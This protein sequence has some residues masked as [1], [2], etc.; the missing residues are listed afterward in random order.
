MRPEGSWVVTGFDA[1]GEGLR[2]PRRDSTLT[3]SILPAGR[4]EGETPCGTYVGG[5]TIDG[6]R[7][8]MGVLSPGIE[9][10]GR[11]EADEA[12]ELTQA[13]ALVTTWAPGPDGL[14]LIDDAGLV[15]VSL[16]SADA[17]AAALAGDWRVRTLARRPGDLR[18]P[19]EG[20]ELTISFGADGRATGTTGCRDFEAD[21]SIEA[22]RVVIA[23]IAL[24]GLPCEGDLRRQ[25]A[26][27]VGH[28]DD[29]VEWQRD[30]EALVLIGAAGDVLV[31]AVSL[32]PAPGSSPVALE[33]APSAS[34]APSPGGTMPSTDPGA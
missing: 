32:H 31:D 12:F 22:D 24:V 20:T 8:R 9:P 17:A 13:L 5:Y 18:P 3:V 1:F 25:E 29:T 34:A 2:A 30:G 16:V 26:R 33:G 21:T 19:I 15:R 10:C 11:R 27:F 14:A 23:P 4:L 6:D 28:L 7:L